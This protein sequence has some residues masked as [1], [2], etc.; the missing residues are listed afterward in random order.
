MNNKE[1]EHPNLPSK[2]E[3]SSWS[4][5]SQQ[6]KVSRFQGM[7]GDW[8]KKIMKP[9][10]EERDIETK[11][12][13][14]LESQKSNKECLRTNLSEERLISSFCCSENR[15]LYKYC[16]ESLSNREEN[17]TFKMKNDLL[18]ILKLSQALA[19]VTESK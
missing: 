4:K 16:S 10:E 18:D 15:T 19:S 1:N 13:S 6:P 2:S 7:D 14:M 3:F 12:A 8:R 5:R 17:S 11:L 9:S